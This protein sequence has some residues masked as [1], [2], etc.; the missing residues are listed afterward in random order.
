V[1][2][3]LWVGK[4][5]DSGIYVVYDPAFQKIKFPNDIFL[6]DIDKQ[7]ILHYDRAKARELF[8]KAQSDVTVQKILKIYDNWQ[9]RIGRKNS[10][11]PARRT[12]CWKCW[13]N[14]NSRQYQKCEKCGW[15]ICD[16]GACGCHYPGWD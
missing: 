9:V 6:F 13:E 8:I 12:H 7:E 5:R 10:Q 15:I 11:I 14:L 3:A 2:S 4:Y 16:C 1:K